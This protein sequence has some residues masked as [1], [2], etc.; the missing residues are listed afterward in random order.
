MFHWPSVFVFA[1]VITR[2]LAT[3]PLIG[4]RSAQ[5]DIGYSLSE[6]AVRFQWKSHESCGRGGRGEQ[7]SE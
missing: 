1:G 5:Q 2:R 7:H 3:L 4:S 6:R